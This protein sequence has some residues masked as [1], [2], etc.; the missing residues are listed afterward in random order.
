MLYK[1]SLAAVQCQDARRV[2]G[3]GTFNWIQIPV[4]ESETDDEI[5]S[6]FQECIGGNE[7]PQLPSTVHN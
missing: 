3:D 6:R 5:Q 2:V 7:T 1:K 4:I